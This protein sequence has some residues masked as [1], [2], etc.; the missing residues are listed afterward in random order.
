MNT[1]TTPKADAVRE[2]ALLDLRE[3]IEDGCTYRDVIKVYNEYLEDNQYED[4][5]YP[6]QDFEDICGDSFKKLFPK[7][8][9][10]FSFDSDGFWFQ[11]GKIHSGNIHK[12]YDEVVA[13]D[14]DN[15]TAWVYDNDYQEK[16]GLEAE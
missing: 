16:L 7:L 11:G 3:R 2:N 13:Y 15:F 8:S 14:L 1:L 4:L 10:E 9:V 6:M 12:Y 5:F